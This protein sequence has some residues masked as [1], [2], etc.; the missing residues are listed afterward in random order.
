MTN[1]GHGGGEGSAGR[2][3]PISPSVQAAL[4]EF[5]R[6]LLTG[7]RPDPKEFAAGFDAPDREEIE[8]RVTAY[9]TDWNGVSSRDTVPAEG[10]SATATQRFGD[11]R[12]VAELGRGGMGV[13]YLAWDEALQRSVALKILTRELAQNPRR[14]ARFEREATAAARLEH[15]GIV[16][17]YRAG[18][19]D[20]EH[21]IA[22]EYVAGKTLNDLLNDAR[23]GASHRPQNAIELDSNGKPES[24]RVARIALEIAEALHHAHSNGVIHRDV[25]PQNVLV[26]NTGR[27]RLADFGL[28]KDTTVDSISVDGE[29]AGSYFYMSPEQ[30]LAASSEIDGR[31][32]V[33][34]LG[35]LLYEMLTLERPFTGKTPQAI[36]YQISFREPTP[37]GRFNRR[38]ARDLVV[39][40][41]K[42]MEKKPADRYESA[43]AMADDLRRF[44]EDRPILARPA[45]VARRLSRFVRHNHRALYA[46][47]AAMLVTSAAMAYWYRSG[48][49]R[50]HL[51]VAAPSGARVSIRRIDPE[52][53]IPGPLTPLGE[54]PLHDVAVERGYYRVVT[55]LAGKG[56][57]EQAILLSTDS[58]EVEL[59]PILRNSAEIV[60][61]GM[62]LIP[63]GR[64][65]VGQEGATGFLKRHEA[66]YNA[67]WI[68]AYEVT[69]AEY[70]SFVKATGHREP[71]HWSL[72]YRPEW[73]DLP[74]CCVNA[75]DAQE[76]AAWAGKRLPTVVEWER[77]ARGL[78]GRLQLPIPKDFSDP[79]CATWLRRPANPEKTFEERVRTYSTLALSVRSCPE[80]ATEDGVF[81]L[82]GNVQ[83]W[84]ESL[85]TTLENGALQ[86]RA[87]AYYFR[88]G[89][90]YL[91]PNEWTLADGGTFESEKPPTD[92]GFRCAK[93]F[94]P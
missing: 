50:P 26:D 28:A 82:F 10:L 59:N 8:R 45:G 39:I 27:I 12:I 72:G 20:G 4:D 33:F 73:D 75:R 54:A 44:L 17:V 29:L 5:V 67:F 87:H 38:A 49:P 64:A 9:L 69:N 1:S 48:P 88:G 53:L 22:M 78:E 25:K 55:E 13:V 7:E 3:D 71:R 70:R 41:A 74:V 30:A 6:R 2:D 15:P 58:Q 93:S 68:D 21:Y 46:A 57:A 81:H 84:T 31:T 62:V 90:F 51:S 52:T 61:A 77:A 23:Y 47:A 19:Q 65:I 24:R 37:I 11:Y 94:E 36:M 43:E 91:S 35:V 42:A 66:E 89:S 32:D 40:C 92:L 80:L 86:W 83:E 85:D 76:Y 14:L 16:S 60:R 56:F 63:A 18:E 79:A 34:S